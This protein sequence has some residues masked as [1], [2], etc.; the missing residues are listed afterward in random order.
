MAQRVAERER[1]DAGLHAERAEQHAAGMA[2]DELVDERERGRFAR[3]TTP[4]LEPTDGP[5]RSAPPR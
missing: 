5:E 4:D 3:D 1:A 2:D